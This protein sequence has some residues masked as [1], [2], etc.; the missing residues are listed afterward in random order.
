[1]QQIKNH[2]K[3]I[4]P[5]KTLSKLVENES[6]EPMLSWGIRMTFAVIIPLF[7]GL[8]FHKMAEVMWVIV[9]AESIGW[10][11]L[12]GSFAQ[13]ARLL[14]AGAFL[15]IVFG[16]A[17]SISNGSLWLSMA[18]ML[19]VV[20][21][22]TLFKN[23]GER[24]SG[25]SLTVYVIFI[26][27]NSFP[28]SSFEEV[29]FRCTNIGIGGLWSLFVGVVASM[30]IS[31]QTPYK[32]SIAFIWKST[33]GLAAAIGAGWD[34][35]GL[36]KG[37]REIYLKE[38]EV[39]AAIDSSL[40]LYEKR[41]YH[42]N[43]ESENAHQ[44]A[45][46]RKSVYLT[47][48]TLMALSEELENI[49]LKKLTGEQQQSIHAILK[50]FEIICA[51]MTIYTVTS[52]AEEEVLLQSRIIRLQNMVALLRESTIAESE[53]A[54][55][56]KIL[57]FT[58]R[59]IKLV[60]N[61]M[62]HIN[63]VAG[64]QKVYRSYSLMKTL[65]ILH[66][67]HWIDSIR[68]LANINTHSFRYALRTAIIATIALFI[69]KWFEIPHG[70]WLPFTVMI[71]IQPYFGATL[72]KALDRVLGT[73]LGVIVAGILM[74]FPEHL[75]IK[76]L[77][78][79]VS[80]ILMVYFLRTQYSV[81]TF[82]ISVFLVALFAAEENLDNSVIIIRALSTIGGAALAVVGEFAL[83]P[84]WDKKWLPRHIAASINAN[85]N[86]FL[87]TYYPN[88]FSSVHQWT[89]YR[90]LAESS[91]SNAFD[92]FNRYL[93]EPTS[94]DKEYSL[95]YQIISHCI[96]VTRELN[97][98]HI[99]SEVKQK[100]RNIKKFE[101]QK[102]TISSCLQQFNTIKQDLK[103]LDISTDGATEPEILEDIPVSFIPLNDTQS[104]YLD[105]L[106][107]ELSAFVRDMH[108]WVSKLKENKSN[109]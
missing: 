25:L 4:N 24:G 104:I 108:K 37:V 78:L 63:S 94:K 71:V 12:K 51:R 32:R 8:Y 49:E 39:N 41:A 89:H 82:F 11:E 38:K 62:G 23:L 87:F 58:E 84:S 96:R 73:I 66:H 10:V 18:L 48:A 44:M 13:R 14:L 101:A 16:F 46:L 90:R 105:K 53:K 57:H 77:L 64:D 95:Y 35:K 76:E 60:E 80:P 59:I 93:E 83:L 81:A 106:K 28:V 34:G 107:V 86:Y 26:V 61:A 54:Q 55:V 5:Y 99:E 88:H 85:Y 43:H 68:R 31:E 91:N 42:N 29:I 109:D 72:K 75:H 40:Q 98:Y 22:A 100:L 103:S 19:V 21:I 9:A 65:L 1:L 17:G 69:Y 6:Y 2:I 102:V 67:K 70:Y 15:A 79:I 97:N 74:S 45:Q 33:A 52:K 27:A 92:S 30:F 47:S 36:K 3:K 7:Y 50:S 56:D 20:F